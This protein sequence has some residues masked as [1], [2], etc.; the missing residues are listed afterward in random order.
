[1]AENCGGEI[2]GSEADGMAVVLEQGGGEGENSE[3]RE[4]ERSLEEGNHPGS[5]SG[6]SGPG[7]WEGQDRCTHTQSGSTV[8]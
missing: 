8:G 1:M 6:R 5:L 3:G 2:P 7:V 4:A